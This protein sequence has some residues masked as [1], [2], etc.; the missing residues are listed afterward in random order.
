MVP[1]ENCTR[2]KLKLIPL[3]SLHP[4]GNAVEATYEITHT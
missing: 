3:K 4:K 2:G 1:D